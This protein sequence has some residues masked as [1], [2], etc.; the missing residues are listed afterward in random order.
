VI[1][2]GSGQLADAPTRI[3]VSSRMPPLIVAVNMFKI[4]NAL[5]AF[6]GYGLRVG[7]RICV[8]VY[9]Q[10]LRMRREANNYQGTRVE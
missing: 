7:L 9:L 8:F 3:L 10:C 1:V 2:K 5:K 6:V 4:T